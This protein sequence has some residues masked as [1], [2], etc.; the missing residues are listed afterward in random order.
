M[1]PSESFC[2]A[3]WDYLRGKD[4][5]PPP[6]DQYGLDQ[7]SAEV[8]MRLCNVDWRRYRNRTSH[9]TKDH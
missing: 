8:L 5:V 3:Y 1:T 2:C 7:Q 6:P 9:E 4:V